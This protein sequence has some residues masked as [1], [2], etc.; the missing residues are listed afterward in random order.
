M[1]AD[2][3]EKIKSFPFPLSFPLFYMSFPPDCVRIRTGRRTRESIITYNIFLK[4][5]GFPQP[6]VELK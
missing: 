4:K 2:K 5:E 3:K 6:F 1:A